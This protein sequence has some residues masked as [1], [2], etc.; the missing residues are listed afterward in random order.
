MFELKNGE[1]QGKTQIVCLLLNLFMIKY[2][3]FKLKIHY[4]ERRKEEF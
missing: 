2:Q 1:T 4:F 3:V